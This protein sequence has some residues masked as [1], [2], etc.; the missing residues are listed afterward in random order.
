MKALKINR[1]EVLRYMSWRKGEPTE[2]ISRI[3]ENICTEFEKS[4]TPRYVYKKVSVSAENNRVTIDGAVFESEKLAKH[5]ENSVEGILLAAT[6]GVEAD[7]IIRRQT[8][9]GTVN[10]SI[11]QAAGAAMIEQYLDDFCAKLEKE[12]GAVLPRFSPGYGDWSL[13]SGAEIL[14]MCDAEK[15]IGI[16]LTDSYMM[17][18]TKSVTA[19]IGVA[20]KSPIAPFLPRGGTQLQHRSVRN[21]TL[22]DLCRIKNSCEN[23][24]KKDCEFRK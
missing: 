11:A 23:C 20:S 17:I 12:Y 24:N 6:L 21:G 2:D 13:A 3:V 5:L 16:T 4:V 22:N 15:R 10:A 14:R 18:P 9:L 7:N 19:V 1:G 8:V